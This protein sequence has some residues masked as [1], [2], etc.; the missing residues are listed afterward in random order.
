MIISL[1]G[2]YMHHRVLQEIRTLVEDQ[3][4]VSISMHVV[5]QLFASCFANTQPF[6]TCIL[7]CATLGSLLDIRIKEDRH[8]L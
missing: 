4:F 6:S 1:L 7:E 3:L 2:D 8:W 5:L